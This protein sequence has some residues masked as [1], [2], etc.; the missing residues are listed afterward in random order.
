MCDTFVACSKATV[1]GSVIFG[2]N[3]DREPNEVQLLEYHPAMSYSEGKTVRCTYMEI[4]QVKE[5][6]AVL[7]SRPFWMWGAEIGANEKGVVIGNEAVWTK[8]PLKKDSGL[9]GMDLLRLALERSSSAEEALE[10]IIQ[11]LSDYGQGGICGYEDKRM[12]YHNSFILADPHEAWVLETAGHLWAALKV[13]EF[14]SISNGLTIGE[15][16][17]RCHPDLLETAKKKGYLKR[18]ENF[19]FSR[20]FSDWFFTTFS[21]C[22]I[23]Q[24]RSQT[25]LQNKKGDM[26]VISAIE[27]LRDHG[28]KD[29]RPDTHLFFN[30]V[31]GHAANRLT[32]NATQTTGSW[33]A[34]LKPGQETYWATGTSAPCTGIF[35]PIW[36]QEDVLP[37]MEPTTTGTFNSHILW[38]HHEKLHRS[39]LLDYS[40]RIAAYL[41]ERDSLETSFIKKASESISER[42]WSLTEK[43]FQDSWNA[44][45]RWT[46]HIQ[47]IPIQQRSKWMYKRYWKKQNSKVKI[48]VA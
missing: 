27:I 32:R 1:D 12:V 24:K 30:H 26:D 44:T 15:E 11:L 48:S 16:F 5:T 31:C 21:A 4:P 34:H 18:G 41:K 28:V 13:K 43:A 37:H 38:W 10:T 46:A 8:M 9:T 33:V 39:V 7:L 3:S 14:Y 22:R 40:H 2:K 20:C 25:I 42:R 23:R 36:F 17:D 47:D 6:H 29:Y 19:H 45:E 35:K